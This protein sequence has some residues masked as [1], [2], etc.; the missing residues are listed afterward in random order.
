MCAVLWNYNNKD[1]V[2]K[3]LCP[4]IFVLELL[5]CLTPCNFQWLFVDS[6]LMKCLYRAIG[7]K[8]PS[9]YKQI[10]NDIACKGWPA[11][12]Q[13]VFA[14]TNS[15]DHISISM[16][17]NGA[18]W[19]FCCLDAECLDSRHASIGWALCPE[20]RDTFLLNALLWHK[21]ACIPWN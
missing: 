3:I 10:Q 9:R 14:A 4:Q 7:R 8:K 20:E 2:K 17:S 19:W 11:V 13:T 1:R 12:G 21:N 5:I 18:H 16:N 6:G 15:S